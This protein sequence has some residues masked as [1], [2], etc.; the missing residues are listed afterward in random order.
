MSDGISNFA[1]NNPHSKMKK[2]FFLL[3]LFT[4]ISCNNEPSGSEA[5][6]IISKAIEKAGGDKYDNALIEFQFRE[7]FY[8]SKRDNGFYEF[9]RTI[10]DSTNTT[11]YDV[12]NNEGFVRYHG[13]EQ[14]VISDSLSG[15]YAESVNAVHYF[16]QLPFGLNDDAVITEL[17]GQDTINDQEYHEIKVTFKQEGG[18]VDH[19]DIYMYWVNKEKYT[20]DYLAYRFFVND[21]GIRFRKAINPRTIEGIR[22]VDYENY[23]TEDVSTPLQE[24]DDLF[25]KG[26]LIKVSQIEKDIRKVEIQR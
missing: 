22:F 1:V 11:Y 7:N 14:V 17:V 26:E 16:V 21:G 15:L 24:L 25:Q 4:L 18:G 9:T 2:L 20:I 5:D 6:K 13:D 3:F 12:L 19:E 8:T 10:T 23:K